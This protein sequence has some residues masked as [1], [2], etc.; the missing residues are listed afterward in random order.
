MEEETGRLGR[1]QRRVGQELNEADLD[2]G[3]SLKTNKERE[4]ERQFGRTRMKLHVAESCSSDI[5][6][7][8]V[9]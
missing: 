5:I 6:A 9:S 8:F 1:A 2:N 3:I 7:I 4:M